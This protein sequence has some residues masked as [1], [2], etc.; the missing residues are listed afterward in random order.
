M[1]MRLDATRLRADVDAR[2]RLGFY[3][4]YKQQA[5]LVMEPHTALSIYADFA[6]HKNDTDYGSQVQRIVQKY[7]VQLDDV[8]SLAMVTFMIPDISDPAK[9]AKLP[10]SPHKKMAGL[11]LQG[12]AQAED[13][14]AIVHILTAA[15]L[16]NFGDAAAHEI[17]TLFP[18]LEL[19]KYRNTLDT[20]RPDPKK[21]ALGPEVLTLR[22]LFLEQEGRKDKAK[23]MYLEAIK[24]APLKFQRGS[25]HP[26]QLPLMAPWN[27]LGYMLK[28]DKDPKLQ[29]E[30]KTYFEKGALEGDDPVS[31]YELAAFEPRPSEKWLRYTSR[32]AG[33]GHRQASIDLAAFY[34]EL[35]KPGSIALKDGNIRKALSWL[36]GWRRG[37]T[38]ELAR[39]WLQV[40]SN[41][42][43]KPSM[44]QLADY[45]ASIH[46]HEGAMEHLRRMLKPP[47]TANQRE[48]WPELVQVAK[49]RLAG[50]R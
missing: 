10:P 4:L 45:H 18:R 25:R 11:L 19:G 26:L 16:A 12:C 27:A 32:A 42:G 46:D 38:A 21:T 8:T 24:T 33:A 48:E 35:A 28:N 34:Q 36:L 3:T 15:H 20:L 13:P 31:Y 47:S 44:L 2:S 41:F 50:I 29:A 30:A 9:R 1:N 5:V 6:A 39:E 37:S 40:A 23:E 17:L 22:G 7:N 43:H 49:R 14:L